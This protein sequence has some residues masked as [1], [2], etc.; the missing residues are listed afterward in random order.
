MKLTAHMAQAKCFAAIVP[1]SISWSIPR[2]IGI[3][4]HSALIIGNKM[5]LH[6]AV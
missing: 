4:I 1:V 3:K 2:F 6:A 5:S